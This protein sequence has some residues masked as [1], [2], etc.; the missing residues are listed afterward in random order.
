ML[1]KL[2]LLP[3]KTQ[4]RLIVAGIGFLVVITILGITFI[5]QALQPPELE[6]DTN[7]GEGRIEILPGAP[8]GVEDRSTAPV[9]TG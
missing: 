8:P 4:Q 6:V 1:Q 5:Y 3:W 7:T 2:L 9:V